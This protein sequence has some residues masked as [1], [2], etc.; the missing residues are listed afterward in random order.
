MGQLLMYSYPLYACAL[1][2]GLALF[3]MVLKIGIYFVGRE[4]KNCGRGFRRF[5]L[6]AKVELHWHDAQGIPKKAS[7]TLLDISED[8]ARFRCRHRLE[9]GS[10]IFVRV[11]GIN[12]A[13]SGRVRHCSGSRLTRVIGLQFDGTTLRAPLGALAVDFVRA[14]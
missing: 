3:G 13:A 14:A 8:G 7:G 1:F 2:T 4:A 10:V 5:A 9:T 11:R 6:R 12:T